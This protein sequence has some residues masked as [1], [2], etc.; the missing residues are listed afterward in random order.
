MFEG[1]YN[2][3]SIKS[4][5]PMGKQLKVNESN[6]QNNN[7]QIVKMEPIEIIINGSLKLDAGPAGNEN[8][9]DVLKNNTFIGGLVD[10]IAK[11]LNEQTNFGVNRKDLRNKYV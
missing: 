9:I 5:E 11:G 4:S 6:S 2:D 7:A 8:I 3:S 10:L 1:K